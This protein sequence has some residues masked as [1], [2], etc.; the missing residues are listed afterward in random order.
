M[1]WYYVVQAA[2]NLDAFISLLE[3]SITFHDGML[4]WSEKK[5]GDFQEMLAHHVATNLLLFGSSARRFHRIG[6]MVFFV[7]DVSDVTVDL[8]KLANFLKW[9]ATTI[10]CFV[11]MT[12]T[13]V[14]TRLYILPFVIFKTVLT[15]S[16]FLLADGA[17]PLHYVCH[18]HFFYVCFALLISLHF[19]WF[20][21]FLRM[22]KAMIMKN[23]VHDY[24]E[25]KHGEHQDGGKKKQ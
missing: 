2:Y 22:L 9:K 10:A 6:S 25:H 15:K 8:S 3:M 16:H 7:H 18:R 21:M 5:R 19:F 14:V 1:I 24:S 4:T 23:E 11:T 13:W 17:S 12:I 20:L